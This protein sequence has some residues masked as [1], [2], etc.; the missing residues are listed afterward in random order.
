MFSEEE[1]EKNGRTEGVNIDKTE[2]RWIEDHRVSSR[3]P[4]QL[5]MDRISD[6]F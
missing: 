2:E 6:L 5:G 3:P 4:Q 1:E